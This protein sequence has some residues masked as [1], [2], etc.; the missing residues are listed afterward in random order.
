VGYHER[1]VT[2]SSR[3]LLDATKANQQQVAGYIGS[4]AAFGG[5]EHENGL[6]AALT[7]Q[8]D[9]VVLMTDGGYPELNAGQLRLIERMAGKKTEIHCIQFGIGPLQTTQ[10]F[11]M[12]LASQNNGSF[13]Y[14]DVNHWKQ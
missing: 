13:R 11:M 1:T 8:P 4:L 5:T 9:V 12:K 2:M 3:N 10:N 6:V 7:F 14:I